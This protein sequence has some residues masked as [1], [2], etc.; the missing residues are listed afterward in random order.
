[1]TDALWQWV[2]DMTVA[3]FEYRMRQRNSDSYVLGID[4]VGASD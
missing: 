3:V 4:T 1:M 2:A